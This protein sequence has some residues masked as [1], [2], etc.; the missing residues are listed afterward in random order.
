MDGANSIIEEAGFPPVPAIEQLPWR[1]TPALTR[2]LERVHRD[3]VALVG[4][5]SGSVDAITGAGLCLAFQQ[6]ERLGEALA[7]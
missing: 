1:G 4:D 2:R 6:A 5:A 7:A 3:N